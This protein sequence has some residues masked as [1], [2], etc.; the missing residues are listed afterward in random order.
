MQ[1]SPLP[2]R[3]RLFDFPSW[4][5]TAEVGMGGVRSFR[6]L[7]F[8]RNGVPDHG[9]RLAT[10]LA[11]AR[12]L[13]QLAPGR[14]VAA[15]AAA[16]LLATLGAG[17]ADAARL[18]AWLAAVAPQPVPQRRRRAG[19]AGAHTEAALRCWPPPG[20]PRPL[21]GGRGR[22]I[23]HARSGALARRLSAGPGRRL[24][25]PSSRRSGRPIRAPQTAT[26]LVRELEGRGVVRELTGRGSFRAYAI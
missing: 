11:L 24:P 8:M 15:P 14:A 5:S 12:A 17:A 10:A 9:E 7:P 22:P 25:A 26:G 13:H 18:I 6:R 2:R 21:G 23:T 20:P 19:R 1:P 3:L 4:P 16:A